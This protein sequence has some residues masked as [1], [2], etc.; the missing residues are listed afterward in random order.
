MVD[1]SDAADILSCQQDNR[2]VRTSTQLLPDTVD[3]FD[4]TSFTKWIL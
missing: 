1:Y 4:G 3:S 2:Y